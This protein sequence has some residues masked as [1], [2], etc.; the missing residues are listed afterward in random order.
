MRRPRTAPSPTR[1]SFFRRRL[2]LLEDR[3]VP[4]GDPTLSLTISPSTLWEFS[5]PAAATGTV[6]RT[7]FD[8]TKPLTVNLSSSDTT[9]ATVPSSVVIPVGQSSATFPINAIDDSLVD[10]LQT[11]TITASAIA[12]GSGLTGPIV[13]DTSWGNS[14]WVGGTLL[15]AITIQPDGRLVTAGLVTGSGTNYFDFSLTRYNIN[16]S[17][18]TTFGYQGTVR[19]D[20]TGQKDVPE[21]VVV[22]PDGKILVAGTGFNGPNFDWILARYT[23]NGVLDTTFGNGGTVIVDR[24]GT[25]NEIW[26]M[27]VQADGKIVVSG[28]LNTLFTVGRFNSDGTLDTSF[29]TGGTVTTPFG[30]LSSRAMG[31]AIQA[32]GKIVAAGVMSGGNSVSQYAVAR[33]NPDGT[34]DPT[35]GTGGQV[36]TDLP[37]I[38]DNGTDVL[39]QNGKIVVAG[40]TG[41]LTASVY[42]IGLV[43]YNADGSLDTTFGG[44]G[45]GMTVLTA[46]GISAP[47]R[48]ALQ[49]DN[50]L[51]VVG[52]TGA[53]RSQSYGKIYR[54]SPDGL[55]ETNTNSTWQLS[56]A[57]DLALDSAGGIYF[58]YTYGSTG[59]NAYVDKYKSS[60]ALVSTTASVT[61]GD[62]DP[63]TAT[64][65]SYTLDQNGS[66]TADAPGVL[67]N[68]TIAVP[69]NPRVTLN[70]GPAHGTLTL[71]ADGSFTYTPTTG[72][73]GTDSFGY[74]IVDGGAS[75]NVATVSLTIRRTSN[76][77]PVSANDSYTVDEDNVLQTVLSPEAPTGNALS[78]VS[79]PG[80]YIGQGRTWNYGPSASFSMYNP[81]PSNSA[82]TN[83]ISLSVTTSTD[84]WYF[85]FWAPNNAPF[86]PGTTYT[87]AARFPFNSASQ[88]GMD[89]S[90][91]GRGSNTLTGQFTVLQAVYNEAGAL[92]RFSAQFEQ[93]SEGATPAL[94]G[95]I[96]Y[97]FLPSQPGVL[98]NDT[99]ADGDPLTASVVSGPSHG[100]LTFNPNG[101]FHY[102]VDA[103]YN[104]PDSFTYKANDGF[105]D[106]NI[107]TA[108]ITV[109]PV[110]DPPISVSDA[111]TT[112]EET[113]LTVPV[114]TGVLAND[115]DVEGSPLTAQ[116]LAYPT[117]GSVTLSANGSFTYTP[118]HNTFGVDTFTYRAFDGNIYG[119]TAT[120]NITI[121]N[122]YDPPVAVNDT[123]NVVPDTPFTAPAPGVLGNDSNPDARTLTA[124][125]VSGPVNGS[126]TLNANGSF[127]YTRTLGASGPD[128]F[129]YK[130][131]DG[132]GESN[133]ATVRLNVAPTGVADTYSA[134][135]DAP[136]TVPVAYGVLINDTDQ[137]G[138]P[139]TAVFAS[140]PANG[141]VSLNANGSFTYTPRANFNGTDSFTYRPSD[142]ITNGS[143]TTVTITVASVNDAPVANNDSYTTAGDAPLV[144]HLPTSPAVTRLTMQSDF[145]DWIGQGRTYDVGLS[146]GTFTSQGN[147]NYL[148]IIYQNRTNSSD[149]WWMTFA[150]VGSNALTQGV[151]LNAQRAAFRDSGHPGLDVTGQGR[152]SNTLTGQFTIYQIVADPSGKIV[153]FGA[154][155]E[156]HSEGSA[157][158]LHG[159]LRFNYTGP[160]P[161]PLLDND[162]DLENDPLSALLV[163][164]PA[165]GTLSLNANGS[166]VYT[167]TPG[168][169]GVDTFS[170][171]ANDGQLDS[172]VA[173]VTITVTPGNSRP[174]ATDDSYDATEDTP[175]TMPAPGVLSNDTDADGDPLT[176]ALASG[177]AHGAVTFNANGSFT[178][179]PATN[180]NGTDSFTYTASDGRLTSSPATV[181]LTIA[182][183]N[184]PPVAVVDSYS[185][186]EDT[187]L[188]MSASNGVLA[189]DQDVDGDSLSATLFSG[190]AHGSLTLN[191]DG[192]FIYTPDGNY[193]GPDSFTYT[194]SDGMATS[195][196]AT[197]SLTI[198]GVNDPPVAIDDAYSTNEDTNLTVAA[199][200]GVLANDTDFES[201]PLTA[202]FVSGPAHGTLTLNVNGSF[203]YTPAA[204]WSGTDSF[205][206]K[207]NDG[208]ADSNVATVTITVNPANDAPVAAGDAYSVTEDGTLDVP[209]PGVLDNDTDAEGDSL[210]AALVAGPAHGTVTF[211]ADGSFTY[212][213]TTNYN[214]SDSF[215]Y[216]ANDDSLDSNVA[217][218]SL[219][220]TP[221]NDPPTAAADAYSTKEDTTLSINAPGVLANDTDIDG[222]TLSAILVSG[223]VH[224]TVALNANG[225]LSYTPA[226]NWSG[227]DSFTYKVNDGT[228]D[229]NAATVTIT[230]ASV[231]DP[232]TTTGIPPVTV[233]EDAAPTSVNLTNSFADV[234][235]G[236]AG[237][238]YSVVGNT[239]AGLFSSVS[240][241]AGTVTLGIAANANGS[242]V[243]TIRA[244]DS[245]GASIETPLA[246]TVTAVN[247]APSFTKGA[248]QTATAGSGAQSVSGWA[249]TMSAGPANESGQ[250]LWF[251]VTTTNP[252]LFV[253]APAIDASGKLTF[254]PE[255]GVSGTATVTVVLRDD[256][257]TADGG[258]DSSG[259]Q[260]FTITI[261]PAGLPATP[262]VRKIGTEVVITGA[263]TNDTV[264]V[265]PQGGG[266]I[267]VTAKLNGLSYSQT[268]TG[269]TLVRVD[270]QGGNDTI[271][272]A[273]N[274]T[275]PTWTDAGAGNDTVTGG[276]GA[277]EIY[278]GPGD[279]A[280]DG[281]AGDDFIA[282]GTGKDVLQGGAGDD[283]IYGGAGNDFVIGGTGA[284]L[285]FGQD[286]H[287]IVVAGT[288]AVRSPS[289]D[290]LRKVLTDWDPAVA[291]IYANIRARLLVTDD[292]AVDRLTGGDGT[293]WFWSSEGIDVLEDI[294]A[295]EQRN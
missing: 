294:G 153:R 120:V 168:F 233:L 140:S 283:E 45:A 219:T 7:N 113:T 34:L 35:F 27:V 21:V 127:T 48:V 139:L 204:N 290:S 4:D 253:V 108:N 142:G 54:L 26:D 75:S 254:L 246:V 245:D 224:G 236:A 43:R 93:H 112:D 111:Y 250:A 32:D 74:K 190:P 234:E 135:E 3:T 18:D 266:K 40:M 87:G 175:F 88:P 287:D 237:L 36:Q 94:R 53:S 114:T 165:H 38:Y 215:T 179:T 17:I 196:P 169:R 288:A 148:S 126:F 155:F 209:A 293:D 100:S 123:Y 272:F 222:D 154:D 212:T 20:V 124:V 163:T 15:G 243:L 195:D 271:T 208:I 228:A 145:G 286:D 23:A 225:S 277:D 170:Y 13:Y 77:L 30:T 56:V 156:Q 197:V 171:K 60:G 39:I 174:A 231:N 200:S 110:N 58:A 50:R 226:A 131:S 227:T 178:Y 29:G 263:S 150:G 276:G 89:V 118:T 279:D 52:S 137:D 164:G 292:G 102:T 55:V 62:N 223:P 24:A 262:G 42:D 5:G 66:L 189:N 78:M 265:T 214:G 101:T 144:V 81:Y 152:G 44:S 258:V 183:A 202:G 187:T 166:F 22:Q 129:T 285:L 278:A 133:V 106:G 264:S 37:G 248:N 6:T 10:G 95:T 261:N 239:N 19:T 122:T 59:S 161:L 105:G 182:P 16:G 158:A 143:V 235:D 255:A 268:F 80:D 173:T 199:G 247:D 57:E 92:T 280:V 107:A 85:S 295:G 130:I 221:V 121:N 186:S 141:S 47:V 134:S 25:Y 115:T 149:Y 252:G 151:Y 146:T 90:G 136:L 270:A 128:S 193:N 73:F 269:A 61:V 84:W 284:D 229:S 76:T 184:D 117:R 83:A 240:V 67:T 160:D 91:N 86:V 31:V 69:N 70:S 157:P 203:S 206:Y 201:D 198:S 72:Y 96:R 64:S 207:A 97:N 260:T 282:G 242:A 51:V 238:T 230:V 216:K 275:L 1:V 159:Q 217:T 188:T 181:S 132:V 167:P 82:Y 267:K 210:T 98:N 147:T 273:N 194:A 103:N 12:P 289:T 2:E 8:L 241:S 281:G 180:Y 251:V 257:G 125:L 14:G 177:P 176:A 172:N 244:T 249:T 213:P 49:S 211:N 28:N 109:N 79:D 33:Y 191:S 218:V 192:S 220:V 119:N 116:L 41:R 162:T 291:G 63:F 205:T 46:G 65:D 104:G 185:G 232:P 259:P 138:D 11:A 256:G 71:N 9:E 99:D 274:L 68:D